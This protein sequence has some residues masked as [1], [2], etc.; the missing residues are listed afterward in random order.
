M[1]GYSLTLTDK[2]RSFYDITRPESLRK[3]NQKPQFLL[4]A[5]LS[6]LAKKESRFMCM[7]S[8]FKFCDVNFVRRSIIPLN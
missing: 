2:N 5:S 1:Y 8:F 3:Q 4:T 7:I 6:T